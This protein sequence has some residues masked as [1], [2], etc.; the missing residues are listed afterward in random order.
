MEFKHFLHQVG[1]AAHLQTKSALEESLAILLNLVEYFIFV[2][3]SAL[4]NESIVA[5]LEPFDAVVHDPE[6]LLKL[7][8]F[9][10]VSVFGLLEILLVLHVPFAHLVNVLHVLNVSL[11]YLLN[12]LVYDV[13]LLD[14]CLRLWIL[15]SPNIINRLEIME[16]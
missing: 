1:R 10:S 16:I 3:F 13:C 15:L 11:T 6:L 8:G 7:L 4:V 5:R 14:V 12:V 9:A 2:N